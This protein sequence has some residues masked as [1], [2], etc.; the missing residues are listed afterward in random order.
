MRA[1]WEVHM[2]PTYPLLFW[3]FAVVLS[4]TGGFYVWQSVQVPGD[5]G[6]V[7]AASMSLALGAVFL[8]LG[9]VA[10]RQ[11][12]TFGHKNK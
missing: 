2:M 6:N 11:H 8:C 10:F 9:V 3:V 4:G 5:T 1:S 12:L 7:W